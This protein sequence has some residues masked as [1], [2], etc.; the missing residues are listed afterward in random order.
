MALVV[1]FVGFTLAKVDHGYNRDDWKNWVDGDGDCQNTRHEVLISK[2][3][4][5]VSLTPDGC[6]VISGLW[7]DPY[8][9]ERF[10]D[11]SA[12]SIDHVV[13]LKEAHLSGGAGW[14]AEEKRDYGNDLD[15]PKHLAVVGVKINSI[16]GASDPVQWMPPDESRHCDYLKAW[17][18]VKDKW[19]LLMDSE[20]KRV[21]LNGLKD[22]P[23]S[24]AV[25][26]DEEPVQ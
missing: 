1:A 16:K 20:E 14:S 2:S 10:V 24:S 8:T 9:G 5:P 19:G 4:E 23:D 18:S 26:G 21:V 3:L 22:C 7:I 13:S 11:A 15:N 17:K 6:K 25:G 12:V